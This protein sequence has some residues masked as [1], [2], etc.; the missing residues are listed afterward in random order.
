MQSP[1]YRI[2]RVAVK[3]FLGIEYADICPADDVI[4][5]AGENGSGK[6]SLLAAIRTC[7]AGGKLG[8]DIIRHGADHATLN[9]WLTGSDGSVGFSTEH[10]VTKIIDG[11]G[12]H[13]EVRDLAKDTPEPAPQTY[14]DNMIGPG[15]AL[16]PS[17]FDQAGG[18]GRVSMMLE[19]IGQADEV[20]R[21][22][23]QFAELTRSR[24]TIGSAKRDKDGELKRLQSPKPGDPTAPVDTAALTQ[25]LTELNQIQAERDAATRNVQAMR[26]S[27]VTSAD[28]VASIKAEIASLEAELKT[29][30]ENLTAYK[31]EVAAGEAK[32]KTFAPLPTAEVTAELARASEINAAVEVG[33]RYRRLTGEVEKLK[34]DWDERTAALR[35]IEADKSQLLAEAGFPDA[36]IGEIGICPD[37]VTVK[38]CRWGNVADSHRMVMAMNVAMAMSG[39]LRDVIIKQAAWFTETTLAIARE[40]AKAKGFRLWLEIPGTSEDASV[41]IDNG[42]AISGRAVNA[43]VT[44]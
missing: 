39:G 37:D 21:M 27:V 18:K 40:L 25:R 4:V 38:G 23:A 13:L 32:L 9:V 36:G 22:D 42:V 41:L 29:E 31:A 5:I 28:N 14:L 3:D 20:A 11:K 1:T 16:D 17:E 7:I 26:N 24:Q 15:M 43:A 12:G 2:E 10:Q 6:S 33:V 35:Q 30:T 34:A 44:S 19:A 8:Q